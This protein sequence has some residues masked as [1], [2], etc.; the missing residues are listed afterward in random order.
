MVDWL[1]T[2][3][4]WWG[5]TA[6]GGGAV[7][8][9]GCALMRLTREPAARQR[10]GDVAVVAALLVAVLRFGPAWL[11]LPWPGSVAH[12]AQPQTSTLPADLGSWMALAEGGDIIVE[13]RPSTLETTAAAPASDASWDWPAITAALTAAYLAVALVLLGRWMLGQWAEAIDHAD[14]VIGRRPAEV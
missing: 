5:G 4:A 10:V 1:L 9:A 13:P 3:A 14:H 6:L 2:V 7:L 12:A 11:E 8:L